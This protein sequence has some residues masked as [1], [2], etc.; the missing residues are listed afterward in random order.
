MIY[1]VVKKNKIE[2]K[3]FAFCGV[4]K[5]FFFFLNRNCNQSTMEAKK[6]QKKQENKVRMV[7]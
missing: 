6:K 2:T 7:S 3:K 1:K 5:K 4:A